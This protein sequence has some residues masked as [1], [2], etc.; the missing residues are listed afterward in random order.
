MDNNNE[1]NENLE[2]ISSLEDT[3]QQTNEIYNA[4]KVEASKA[5]LKILLKKKTILIVAVAF[6]AFFLLLIFIAVFDSSN[7]NQY[8]YKKVD[9]PKT[10][11]ITSSDGK[12]ELPTN[13]LVPA[14]VRIISKSS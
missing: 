11:T 8:V 10:V 5:L 2:E 13:S 4:G 1:E 6:L 7:G 12:I 9:Y 3:E 14:P